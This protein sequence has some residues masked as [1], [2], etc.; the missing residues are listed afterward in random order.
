M[1]A[2]TATPLLLT[3]SAALP[4]GT[5]AAL[6]SLGASATVVLGGTAVVSDDVL[7]ELPGPMRI[8]GPDR[9]A[10]AA[11]ILRHARSLGLDF[12]ALALATGENFPDGLTT[13]A[14]AGALDGV[15][16]LVRGLCRQSPAL[17]WRGQLPIGPTWAGSC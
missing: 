7:A 14:L 16:V 3:E 6:D 13:G 5:A 4:P 11:A 2:R 10:T 8:A 17:P 9:Y 12:D 1:A 15:V